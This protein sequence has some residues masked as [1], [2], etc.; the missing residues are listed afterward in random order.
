MY[1]K[2]Y[3]FTLVEI[4]LVV[5]IIAILAGAGILYIQDAKQSARDAQRLLDFKRFQGALTLFK[6]EYG[7]YPCAGFYWSAGFDDNGAMIDQSDSGG[8]GE[9]GFLNAFGTTGNPISQCEGDV[10]VNGKLEGGLYQA[11]LLESFQPQDPLAD[12]DDIHIYTY[13]VNRERDSYVL[14]AH[15]EDNDELMRNDGGRCDKYYEVG[16]GTG[17]EL[18]SGWSGWLGDPC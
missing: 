11:G 3:G 8:G 1:M 7:S 4:L 14:Y 5:A 17:T 10:M 16:P 18:W 12:P 15:L 6:A 13:M 9:Q 2:R